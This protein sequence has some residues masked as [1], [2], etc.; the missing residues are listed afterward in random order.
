MVLS[1]NASQENQYEQ[2]HK[3]AFAMHEEYDIIVPLTNFPHPIK[4]Y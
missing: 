3:K 1:G 4:N 2:L